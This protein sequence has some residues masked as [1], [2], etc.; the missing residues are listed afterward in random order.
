[1]ACSYLILR[2]AA[3]GNKFDTDT[4]LKKEFDTDYQIAI[5]KVINGRADALAGS[6]LT[7]YLL[8]KESGDRQGL[9]D[10]LVLNK[11]PLLL[12]CSKTSKNITEMDAI[13]KVLIKMKKNGELKRI[14]DSLY[15]NL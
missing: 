11:L 2:G 12:Q 9:G 8:A 13:N 10:N 4:K 14:T 15:A 3:F 5:K 7:I 1:M 6:I